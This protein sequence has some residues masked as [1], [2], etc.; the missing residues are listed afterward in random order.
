MIDTHTL[1]KIN[2]YQ[3]IHLQKDIHTDTL[4]ERQTHTAHTLT[5]NK[6]TH[7]L[8]KR[9]T[10]TAHTLTKDKHTHTLTKRQTQT[11]TYTH[12][13]THTKSTNTS[14]IH[15]NMTTL[16]KLSCNLEILPLRSSESLERTCLRL[17]S[18]AFRHKLW[19]NLYPGGWGM[20]IMSYQA[21][22]FWHHV[23]LRWKMHPLEKVAATST[24]WR[25]P[26]IAQM[27]THIGTKS[28]S[29]K[30]VKEQMICCLALTNLHKD[31]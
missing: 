27:C 1:T 19:P 10:H 24:T 15:D 23:Y 2:T 16:T 9:Q 3:H 14:C 17:A 30:S 7:T 22:G 18:S 21:G 25:C 5:K 26:K 31:T 13:H 28:F 8:T 12:T 6:H 4:T 11:H 20:L 29:M